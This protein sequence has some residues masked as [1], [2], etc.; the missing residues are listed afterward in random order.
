MDTNADTKNKLRDLWEGNGGYGGS[1]IGRV[2]RRWL[3]R[4]GD[5]WKKEGR[6]GGE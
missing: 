2:G 4:N 1:K 5:R 6:Q 3:G